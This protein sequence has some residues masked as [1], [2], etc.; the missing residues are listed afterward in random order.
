MSISDQSS[1]FC[2]PWGWQSQG[3]FLIKDPPLDI[4]IRKS[5]TPSLSY[6]PLFPEYSLSAQF[7]DP[8]ATDRA[9]L[10]PW[11]TPPPTNQPL[12]PLS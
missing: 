10:H 2:I 7:R 9:C 11:K 1:S 5:P 4:L 12:V 3:L 6:S 8:P